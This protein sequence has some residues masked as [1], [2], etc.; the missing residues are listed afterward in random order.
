MSKNNEKIS[1]SHDQ[2]LAKSTE[3]V[4][5]MKTVKMSCIESKILAQ[6]DEERSQELHFLKIDSFCWSG[7]TF[8]ASISTVFMASTMM[9]IKSGTIGLHTPRIG[10]A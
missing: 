3:M 1:T 9:G 5:G 10:L 7:M 4:K 6:I 8:L 2:R